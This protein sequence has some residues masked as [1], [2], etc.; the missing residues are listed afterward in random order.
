MTKT[1]FTFIF[2]LLLL[3]AFSQIIWDAPINVAAASSGNN[4]PRIATDASGNPMLVWFHANRVMFS[5]F[6]GTSFETPRIIN[7]VSMTVAG[8]SW[9]GPQIATHGDTVYVVF[10]QTPEDQG[11]SRAIHSYDGGQ[12]FSDAVQI[13][14]IGDSLSRFPT[15]AVDDEGH[16]VVAFMKFNSTFGDA[17]WAVSRSYDF[18]NS[19]GTDVLASGWSSA[20]SDVCDCCPGSVLSSGEN[21][22]MLYRD[23]DSNKRDSWAGL[24]RDG[25]ET[26]VEGVNVDQQNWMISSCPASGPDGVIIGDTLYSTFMNGASGKTR[27]Y[28]N[29]TSLT[30]F[31]SGPALPVTDLLFGLAAQ[32]FPRIASHGNAL[33]IVW[34]QLIS[35][36]EQLVMNFYSD[37]TSGLTPQYDTVDFNQIMNTDIAMTDT[38]IYVVW[39][40]YNS[41]TIR[42]R[43]GTYTERTAVDDGSI[44]NQ[45]SVYPNPSTNKWFVKGNDLRSG[46][47][48]ELYDTRGQLLDVNVVRDDSDVI[49][50]DNSLL[51]SGLYFLR[52]IDHQQ[53]FSGRVIKH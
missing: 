43:T 17:K 16:P 18:G 12:T 34:K 35:G 26:F 53:Q 48:L 42:F 8:A 29:R 10:K 44:A 50:I 46:M 19:F 6:D 2:S 49:E 9:M 3:S 30:D 24:S 36:Q 32:N 47:K 41:G 14:F 23:N 22:V 11:H 37:V 27:V 31:V 40:D 4:H 25:G 52:I 33:A 15:V 21:V 7:P 1:V 13:D 38:K 20:T 51:N 39:E 28:F 5:R 45:L